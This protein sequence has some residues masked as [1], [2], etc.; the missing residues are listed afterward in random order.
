MLQLFSFGGNLLCEFFWQLYS[1]ETELEVP[2]LAAVEGGP[3]SFRAVFIR[4]PAILETGPSVE[5]LADYA[6]SDAMLEKVS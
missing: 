3:P 1:F 4:A 6:V 5:V 2:A